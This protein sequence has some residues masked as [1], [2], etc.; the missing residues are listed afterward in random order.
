MKI[1]NWIRSKITI[2]LI[3]VLVVSVIL[4]KV[5]LNSVNNALVDSVGYLEDEM[6]RT[7]NNYNRLIGNELDLLAQIQEQGRLIARLKTNINIKRL[8]KT[9]VFVRGLSGEGAGT[10]IKKTET[11]MYVLT[12]NHVIE[13]ITEFYDKTGI[14]LGASIGYSKNDRTDYIQGFVVYGAE[15]IKTDKENDLALLKVFMIDDDLEV[16]K[17]ADEEPQKGD[18]VYS[19]GSPLGVLRTVSQGILSNKVEGFYISDNTSTFGNSG[20]GLYN[21]NGE[22]IGVPAQVMGYGN[23][24]LFA[25]ESSLGMSINLPRIKLFLDGEI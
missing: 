13:D 2:I 17:I 20:G 19:V 21:D 11:E 16:A 14:K 18:V 9:D 22:L 8:L 24:E 5:N 12:C 23:G 10:I 15:I 4:L 7:Y 25:P 3:G 6:T 1:A